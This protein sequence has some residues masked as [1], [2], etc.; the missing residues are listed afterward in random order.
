MVREL[1]VSAATATRTT[2]KT[3]REERRIHTEKP[4]NTTLYRSKGFQQQKKKKRCALCGHTKE[5]SRRRGRRRRT[6]GAQQAGPAEKRGEEQFS[7]KGKKRS[8][9]ANFVECQSAR[10]RNMNDPRD[11]TV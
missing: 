7:N 8:E 10:G 9:K 6:G 11:K 2:A 1:Q 4:T 3:K 5:E